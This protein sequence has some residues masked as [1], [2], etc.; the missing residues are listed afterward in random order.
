LAL[1]FGARLGP[2][3]ILSALGAGGMGEVYRARDT[4]LGREVA[5]KILPELFVSDPER[6]ARFQREAKTLAALNHPNI[7]GIHHVEEADGITALVLELVEGPTLADRISQG[8]VPLDEAL[9]IA[10]QITQALEAA[11]EQ[12]IIHR[13]LKPANIKVRAD[14]TVKVLDLGLAKLTENNEEARGV[15][16]H[17]TQSPTITS[18]A[19]MTGVGVILGTAAYMAPEQAKGRSAD[20]RSDM[21]A[22]GVVFFEMLTGQRAFVG[23]DVAETLAQV[24][25]KEPEWSALPAS[26]P[27]AVRR[28]LRRCLSKDRKRRL[29]SAADAGLEI[30][31]ALKEETTAALSPLSVPPVQQSLF[32][33]VLAALATTAAAVTVALWAPWRTIP[34]PARV[35]F[36]METAAPGGTGPLPMF[37]VSPDGTHVV[38]RVVDGDVQKLWVRPLARL[39]GV[40]L[41]RTDTGAYPFWSA[42]GQAIGF[43]A[44]DKLKRI[45]IS[46]AG[47]QT[48]ADAPSGWGGTWNRNGVILFAPQDGPIFRVGQNA[49]PAVPVTRVD[50]T[51][52]DTS[53]RF[54]RFLPDGVH[55]L[56]LVR[57]TSPD[58]A[59]I[60]LGSLASPETHRLVDAQNKPEFA[61]PDLLL[62]M[63]D[64]TLLA[65]HIDIDRSAM[66]GAPFRIIE[67]VGSIV[68]NGA[69]GFSV[70]NNGV[71]AYRSGF[72][73][74][75]RELTWVSRDGKR[76]GTI[77]SPAAYENPRLS[78]N[79]RQLAV[80]KP[81]RGGDIWVTE[82]EGGNSYPLTLNPASDNIPL[83]SP[84]DGRRVAFVS[85]RDGGVFNIYVKNA[86]GTGA[87]QLLFKT[88]HDKLLNDWSPDGRYLFYQEQSP[89][90]GNDIWML[91]VQDHKAS[92]LLNGPFN[93]IEAALSPDGR[94]LAYTSDEGGSRQVYVQKFPKPERK[95]PVSTGLPAA[96]KPRWGLDPK[97]KELFFDSQGTMMAA[98]LTEVGPR[99]DLMVSA[100]VRLFNGLGNSGIHNFD[101]AQGGRFLVL[102]TPGRATAGAPITIVVNWKSGLALGR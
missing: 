70:S 13:D 98:R 83:W 26:T 71:L 93:Q 50:V 23:E 2:Y 54:P 11:H 48:L 59:G 87:E 58:S 8:P 19:Q 72:G 15:Q 14:G 55:F 43:F 33:W 73:S 12:G 29:D 92:A 47:L 31:E 81:E 61:P 66:V 102:L 18:P 36:D 37:A 34:E 30:D 57:S 22:F 94:W 90:T 32:P 35:M 17:L 49:G 5:L 63:R 1:A 20:K 56:Y 77:G 86:G 27:G 38:A 67:S 96:A 74:D 62:F 76:E 6:V 85:N 9:Q 78:P 60:Y 97:E 65:Q 40:T 7:G 99:G 53:H 52:G 3:E 88:D 16:L 44:D 25:T 79:G 84:T 91:S 21:W 68:N 41:Q 46:G 10:K 75:L 4:K 45:E 24:L 39:E 95:V 101:V 28:L 82:V 69:A 80:F 89:L 100:P 64:G 42:D 51:H